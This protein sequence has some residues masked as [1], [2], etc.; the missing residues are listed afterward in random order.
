MGRG[1]SSDLRQPGRS[2]VV[3]TTASL[4]WRTGTAVNPLLRTAY[5]GH[6]LK[7]S[8]VTLL[9]PWLAKCEQKIVYPDG[10]TFETTEE[11]G[12]WIK[13]WVK[14]RTTFPCSF[15]IKFYPGRYDASFLSIFPVGD[16]T[17]FIPD[18]QADVAIL[19]EP[20]HLTWF[21]H[22]RRYTEKFRH[23]IGIMHTNYVDYVR[24]G[25]AGN[26]GG[27]LAARIVAVANRRMCD[28]HCH[29]V[30]KLSD[31]VQHL[32]RESTL[33]VHGVPPC[34]LSVGDKMAA[35]AKQTSVASE[36]AER[37][38]T[39]AAEQDGAH[40]TDANGDSNTK[41]AQTHLEQ[42]GS[43][44][45]QPDSATAAEA[46]HRS[47]GL[48]SAPRVNG[49]D[50]HPAPQPEEKTQGAAADSASGAAHQQ[51]PPLSDKEREVVNGSGGEEKGGFKFS[52]GAY[53]IGKAVWGKGYTELLELLREHRERHGFN[54]P[55]DVFGTGEDLDAIKARAQQ[56]ELEVHFQ[57]ARDH[58]D[59]SIHP[60]RVFINP[61]TSDVVATTSAEALAMGKWLLCAEHPSN[62]FFTSFQNALIYTSAE[63][64]SEKLKYSEENSPAPLLAE[65]R[66]RLT[67][68]N[69]TERLLDAAYMADHEWPGPLTRLKGWLTWRIIYAGNGIEPVRWI[70]GAGKHTKY[71]PRDVNEFD[72]H[73]E[74]RY[75][76]WAPDHSMYHLAQ[77][78][79][80][81]RILG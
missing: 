59:D 52:K 15:T 65:D 3:I 39:T 72:P 27:P 14:E 42:N 64:F 63:E 74:F 6:I 53:F 26:A 35:A 9:V 23:V 5:L 7:D 29:K 36:R 49:L 2:I 60:Y 67:W 4:P 40:S 24:R 34:F 76:D 51:Q 46:E 56:Y 16:P 66:K 75:R 79:P 73:A 1:R 47:T 45:T 68:E 80:P 18:Y 54:L 78:Y 44:N 61:S 43:A 22:G 33:F 25:G 55:V 48:P 70:V 12:K 57:G 71:T 81:P 37:T 32:P 30:I 69:A 10:I 17:E 41:P 77:G 19:E 13:D 8:K 20:E 31:A 28:I 50:L 38:P 58:L 62:D 21:H 11:Q